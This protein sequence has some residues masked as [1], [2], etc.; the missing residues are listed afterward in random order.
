[1]FTYWKMVQNMLINYN[2]NW[3]KANFP[4]L[5][6]KKKFKSIASRQISMILKSHIDQRNNNN[7]P[8]LNIPFLEGKQLQLF[9]SK[10]QVA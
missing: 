10:D 8:S 9:L 2:R 6:R 3:P 4:S 7:F 5:K 1:M